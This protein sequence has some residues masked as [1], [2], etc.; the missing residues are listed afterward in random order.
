MKTS[1]KKIQRNRI[2]QA[3]RCFA[4]FFFS[5]VFLFSGCLYA[6][7]NGNAFLPKEKLTYGAYYNW[8]FIW[9][10]AGEVIFQTDTTRQNSQC[11]W[12]FQAIGKT[13][14]TYDIFYTVRDTFQSTVSCDDF[15]PE[16]FIRKM[17]HA[18]KSTVHQYQFDHSLGKVYSYIQRKEGEAFHD[19]LELKAS[20]TDL[21]STVYALRNSSFNQLKIGEQV[22][23]SMLVDNKTEDLYFRYLGEEDVKTRNGMKFRCHQVLVRL[24]GGD[25]FPDGEY[26]KVWFTNDLNHI[27]VKVETQ[28]LIGSVNAILTDFEHLKYPL[29]SKI[30]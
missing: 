21:M 15:K 27:P 14:K 23:F 3:G 30:K 1:K 26:M 17:D 20:S 29:N 9:V 13:Y 10:N 5:F 25:F 6:Q 2:K 24:L 22:N 7:S 19:T 11:K 12:Q 18:K 4:I 16:Y 28:I 8:H